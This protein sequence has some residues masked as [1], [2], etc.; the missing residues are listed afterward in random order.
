MT[1]EGKEGEILL[2]DA[3][4]KAAAFVDMY[5]NVCKSY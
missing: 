3:F 4:T 2:A 1:G 5:N